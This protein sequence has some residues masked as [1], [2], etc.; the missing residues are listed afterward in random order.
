ML[1]GQKAF[2]GDDLTDTIAA[3]VRAEPE[4]DALPT[5]A[6]ARIAAVLR[7]C[8]QKERLKRA[9]AIGDV[10]LALEGS[11]EASDA[12]PAASGTSRPAGWRRALPW[13]AGLVLAALTGGS[14]WTLMRP[15]ATVPTWLTI[16]PPSGVVPDTVALSRDGQTIAFGMAFGDRQ[17][18]VYLRRLDA[19]EAVPARGTERALALGFSPNGEWL[20]VGNGGV[21]QK[22]PVAGGR[23]VTI[24][25]A[26]PGGH[27]IADW[28]PGD[29]IVS[30]SENGLWTVSASGGE[31]QHLLA[32]AAG[33]GAAYFV[34]RFLPSGRAVLFYIWNGSVDESQVAVYDF[35]SG[36]HQVLLSGTSPQF[37]ASGHLVF[38]R[39]DS[40]WAVPF[41]PDG[42]RVGGEPRLVV[43]G[44]QPRLLGWANYSLADDGTL[45][46]L[47]AGAT[48][49]STIGWVDRE[50]H[51][52]TPLV[53]GFRV[54]W[55][56][57][58][59]D[60]AR[61][62]FTRPGVGGDQDVWIRNLERG[63]ETRLTE[64]GQPNRFPIW[65]PDGTAVTFNTDRGDGVQLHARPV[66]LSSETELDPRD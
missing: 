44:V 58:S 62:A 42:L 10:I 34:P 16:V 3:V 8:L 1:S 51:M 26:P 31:F 43:E 39:D 5:D 9:R 14:V 46:Y 65:I 63:S 28:G 35:D 40:L 12:S 60:G 30:G 36:Q 29:M 52:Q 54:A 17:N 4:Y 22:V 45:V 6:P 56:R 50:G 38:F 25:D 27:R 23:P 59:P 64:T 19:P 37:A 15:P 41:D 32:P 61:V 33:E 18:Q 66:D 2:P 48:V 7:S 49:T 55:P 21:L 53:E 13:V 20:L 47:P 57:I 11:F 24:A